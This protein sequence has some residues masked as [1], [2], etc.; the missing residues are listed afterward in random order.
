MIDDP[1]TTV[2]TSVVYLFK[3]GPFFSALLLPVTSKQG[4]IVCN[5]F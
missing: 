4:Y 1:L 5:L 2:G 3:D